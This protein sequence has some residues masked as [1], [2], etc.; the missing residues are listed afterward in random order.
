[1]PNRREVVVSLAGMTSLAALGTVPPRETPSPESA[2]EGLDAFIRAKMERDRIPGVAACVFSADGIR[3]IGTYGWADIERR[4]RM[5]ADAIQNICSISKTFTTTALMQ[6]W[7]SGKFQL[8]DDVNGYLP[9]EVR[10]PNHAS[11]KITFRHLL[12]HRSSIRDGSSYARRYACGDPRMSL[13]EWLQSYFVAGG[14]DYDRKENFHPFAPGGGWDYCN[15]AYG[16][17]AF[18]AERIGGAPFAAQCRDRIF[19]PLEMPETSWY[20]ADIDTTRHVIPYT[21]IAPDGKVRGPSWGGVDQGVIREPGAT[22]KLAAGMQPNCL[23]NHPN[24]PDGFL[25]TSVV[26]LSRYA[27]A[28]LGEGKLGARRILSERAVRELLAEQ[29]SEG[30]RVQGLTWYASTRNIRGHRAWGHGGSDP[31]INTDLRIIREE[32]IGA[33]AFMNTN[34]VRPDEITHKML[35]LAPEL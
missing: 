5:T 16:L 28:Y 13:G 7:E 10:N 25:R 20:L 12:T 15:V 29:F 23:Y 6:L 24:F 4:V 18:L 26:Q 3:W 8:D 22:G 11:A 17:T 9:F 32:A 14:A 34:G 27:R 35:E 33:I 1:M 30:Q 2:S 21:Y 31:G 19:A